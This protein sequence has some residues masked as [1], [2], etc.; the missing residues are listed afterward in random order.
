MAFSDGNDLFAGDFCANMDGTNAD[1]ELKMDCLTSR[2]LLQK[3][4]SYK[5]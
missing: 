2:M 3:V 4:W 1:I 5:C